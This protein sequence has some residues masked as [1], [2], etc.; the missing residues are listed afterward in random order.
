MVAD[1]QFVSQLRQREDAAI[2]TLIDG[3]YQRIYRY[4]VHLVQDPH[5]AAELTQDTFIKIYNALPT[6]R[7]DSHVT[8]WMFQIATNVARSYHRRQRIVRWLPLDS[9]HH[10]SP[11]HEDL[12]VE[13]DMVDQVLQGLSYEQRTALLLQVWGGLSCAEI[14]STMGKSEHAVKMILVRGR[15][16]FRALYEQL[17]DDDTSRVPFTE[18]GNTP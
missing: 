13:R 11:G 12:T 5:T 2:H 1:Q 16:Q 9:G 18:D 6:L 17:T 8:G 7:D 10:R 3:S 14:A 4:L 15:R